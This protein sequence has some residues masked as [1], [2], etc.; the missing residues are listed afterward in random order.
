[1]NTT[2]PKPLDVWDSLMVRA[3]KI[4]EPS[5]GRFRRVFARR[6]ALKLEHVYDIH[7]AAYMLELVERYQLRGLVDMMWELHPSRSMWHCPPK[8]MITDEGEPT[9]W[10]SKMITI[11]ASIIGGTPV[12]KLPGLR[13]PSLFNRPPYNS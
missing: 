2:E 10:E 7:I 1:M 13:S 12:D 4:Q 11:C 9:N 5:M 8:D 6:C 3:C